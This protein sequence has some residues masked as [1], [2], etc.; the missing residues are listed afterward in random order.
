MS[1]TGI[2]VVSLCCLQVLVLTVQ[3]GTTEVKTKGGWG[4]RGRELRRNVGNWYTSGF[5]LW[6][7]SVGTDNSDGDSGGRDDR[8]AGRKRQRDCEAEMSGTGIPA[9]SRCGLQV[10]VLTAQKGDYRGKDDRWAEK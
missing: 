5:P 1:R 2:L 3:M 7:S 10:L 9:V 8:W 4:S 6:S